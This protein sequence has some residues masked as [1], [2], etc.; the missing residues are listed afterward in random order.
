M[1]KN[2]E[3][4]IRANNRYNAKAYDEMKFRVKK[5]ERE[6]LQAYLNDKGQSLNGFVNSCMS[7]CID[8]NVDTANC[9]PLGD[10]L[11]NTTQGG[12]D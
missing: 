9:K 7:Y 1:A 12:D 5:G 2:S 4:R 3:A 11:P 10:V 8:N 6:R